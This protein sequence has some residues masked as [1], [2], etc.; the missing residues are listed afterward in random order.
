MSRILLIDGHPDPSPERFIH[1][2]AGAYAAGAKGLHELRR[3]DLAR[4]SFPILRSRED[5]QEGN[6]PPEIATAQEAI[7]WAEH[8]VILFPLWLGDMPALLKALFEQVARPGFAFRYGEGFP[9][10]LLKGR[11]ARLVVTMGMPGF[12][13][14]LIYRAHSLKSLKRNILEFVGIHPVHLNVIGGVE[15]K[16]ERRKWWLEKMTDLGRAA[17]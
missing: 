1:A 10:K 4:M 13:Y 9:E 12:F 11:S 16:A 5:W 7:R 3:I 17:A 2:L 6:V 14:K 15:G 8:I